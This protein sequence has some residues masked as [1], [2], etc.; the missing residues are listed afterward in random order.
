MEVSWFDDPEHSSGTIGA[1]LSADASTVRALVGDALGL[2]IQ[3]I[4]SSLTGLVIAFVAS[5]E[6]ALIILV[7][8]PLIGVNGY[9][10][11]KFMK[12]FSA[13]AK[14]MYEEA[15]QVANDAVGS[16]RTVAS[17]YAEDKVMELY[18]KKCE[19]PMKY[20]MRLGLISGIKFG[21]SFFLLFSVNAT[22]FYSGA[23]LVDAGRTTFSAVF[24][25]FFALTMTAMAV[26]Q[27]SSMAPDSSKAKSA[28]SSIFE[29]LP[30]VLIIRK[31]QIDPSDESGATLDNVKGE[32]E[33]RHVSFKYLS[34]PDIHKF[35]ETSVWPFIRARQWPLL[36]RVEAGNQ[37]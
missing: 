32:I 8:I 37:Q 10:Q 13:D 3:N 20:G 33:L 16:I 5:W 22:S 18:R 35:S 24:R 25:V 30:L 26:S 36:E 9:V 17:F 29:L 14:M 1:R 11:M 6:L 28:T 12:G 21:C 15:S 27:S 23:R 4:A 2:L 7:I 31:S 34:R 19:G